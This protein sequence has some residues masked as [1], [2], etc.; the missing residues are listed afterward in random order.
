MVRQM[1]LERP[2]PVQAPN[3]PLLQ[4]LEEER[5]Q[6]DREALTADV[7]MELSKQPQTSARHPA[8][9]LIVSAPKSISG[10]KRGIEVLQTSYEAW[11]AGDP[12]DHEP[13][14][15]P[16]T[17]RRVLKSGLA[18]AIDGAMARDDFAR[19][20][21][22]EKA[23]KK[24]RLSGRKIVSTGGQLYVG[25]ARSMTKTQD[26]T[27]LQ[28][29]QQAVQK[30]EKAVISK[31]KSA[32]AS[33]RKELRTFLFGTRGDEQSSTTSYVGRWKARQENA[34]LR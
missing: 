17:V 20:T 31:R 8:D 6:L 29:L 33:F 9:Q 11:Y 5:E 19:T 28:K 32:F 7:L 18:L 14:P 21:A 10:L 22:A 13:P 1:E 25:D 27:D 23:R 4:C 12:E 26:T 24:R 30:E 15:S 16:T 34:T 3:A 2:V